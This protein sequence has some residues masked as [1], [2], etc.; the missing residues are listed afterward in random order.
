[1]DAS[2]RQPVL[3]SQ[4]VSFSYKKPETLQDARDNTHVLK[5]EQIHDLSLTKNPSLGVAFVLDSVMLL[6]GKPTG[7]P[8]VR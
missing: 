1:M 3:E 4:P 6:L 8:Q 7:W 5:E 2:L